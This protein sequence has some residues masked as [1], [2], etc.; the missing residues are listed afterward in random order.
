MKNTPD[1]ENVR[2]DKWLWAA[3]FFKTRALATDAVGGG[4]V[5]VN[6]SR[7]KPGKRIG[8]GAM[9]TLQ[10]GPIRR[11]IEVHG[12]SE[13]RGPA[14]E[15]IKLYRETEESI[16]AR[17]AHEE[18]M[19]MERLSRPKML[20]RPDKKSRRQLRDLVRNPRHDS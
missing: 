17:A 13:R 6:G 14:K 3:R 12:L 15:A 19:K 18:V 7:A 11:V 1:L 8:V 16:A 9:V 4:K 10:Q 5:E 2:L 20:G